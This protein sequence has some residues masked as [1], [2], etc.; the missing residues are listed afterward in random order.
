MS[1]TVTE[2]QNAWVRRVLQVEPRR[3]APQ[4]PTPQGPKKGP[5]ADAIDTLYAELVQVEQQVVAARRPVKPAVLAGKF[6]Y[7]TSVLTGAARQLS[8]MKD[9]DIRGSTRTKPMVIIKANEVKGLLEEARKTQLDRSLEALRAT[10]TEYQRQAETLEKQPSD[11]PEAREKRYQGASARLTALERERTDWQGQIDEARVWMAGKARSFTTEVEKLGAIAAR[12]EKIVADCL[13]VLTS[14][15][16]PTGEKAPA[17]GG[18]RTVPKVGDDPLA[19]LKACVNSWVV[20]K[21]TYGADKDQMQLLADYREKTVNDWL[22]ENLGPWDMAEGPG[23]G[24]VSVGS[25]DPTSDYDISINKHGQQRDKRRLDY[26]FVKDFN[27]WFRTKFGAE[28]GTVFDTN[29]YASAPSLVTDKDPD[30]PDTNDVAALMKLR[31][32]MSAGEFEAFRVETM[33]SCGKDDKLRAKTERQFAEADDNFRVVISELLVSGRD[34]LAKRISARESKP[35][36]SEE[37]KKLDA[38]ERKLLEEVG[39][40]LA[41]GQRAS[42]IA[43]YDLQDEAEH[44]AHELDHMLKD[45]TLETTNELYADKKGEVRIHEQA[46]LALQD[47]NQALAAP[48]LGKDGLI[49]ALQTARGVLSGLKINGTEI[50]SGSIKTAIAALEQG[51][52]GSFQK[53][54]EKLKSDLADEL[55]MRRI[56]LGSATAIGMFFANEA[57]Q[58]DGPFAHVVTATQAAESEATAGVVGKYPSGLTEPEKIG[59]DAKEQVAIG[60]AGGKEAFALLGKD[61][62]DQKREE[63]GTAIDTAVKKLKKERQ[64]LMPPEHCLQSFNEQL[65]DFLKDLEHYGDEAPGKAIIQSSK[66]LD[67]LIDAVRLMADK[68]MFEKASPLLKE[69]NDQIALQG[70]IKGELIAARKGNLVLMPIEGEAPV[71]Q[72]EQRRAYAC[73][74]MKRLGVT[75][76]AGLARKYTALGVKINAAARRALATA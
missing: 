41:R 63:A 59:K 55:G 40:Y 21:Q 74:F 56:Q 44:L 66:Y 54:L 71:D 53:S 2:A 31:R 38:E 64:D 13:P 26:E 12:L 35:P 67:R 43:L 17:G 7:A 25:K 72:E 75:S 51:D 60:M 29:L 68:D 18:G 57:Y 46:M 11:T 49:Q 37:E 24:W 50:E 9:E 8:G 58:S 16:A 5:R 36:T 33:K 52:E 3:Q 76:V 28:G 62:Q 42:G 1:T 47:L 45:A 73:D 19:A 22:K 15:V 14:R 27:A 69:L 30:A 32:Y 70:R 4:K 65:G 20:A 23:K 10:V 61:E 48:Q 39:A 6:G 34:R